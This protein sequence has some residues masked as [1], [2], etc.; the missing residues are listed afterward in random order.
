LGVPA[1]FV[2]QWLCNHLPRLLLNTLVPEG[3]QELLQIRRLVLQAFD[4]PE[5]ELSWGSLFV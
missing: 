3:K 1:L 2:E 5:E 4:L